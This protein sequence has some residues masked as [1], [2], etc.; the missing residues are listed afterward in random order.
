MHVLLIATYELGHQ[1]YS[2]AVMAARLQQ[3]GHHTVSIDTSL[4]PLEDAQIGAADAIGLA[5][6]MHTATRLAHALLPRLRTLNPT[7]LII[8]FGLYA[9]LN[10]ELLRAAGADYCLAGEVEARFVEL[11]A[12]RTAADA[13]DRSEII[14]A[15]RRIAGQAAAP[16]LQPD[17]RGF[18]PLD[19]YAKLIT[20]RGERIAGYT[21][22][23]RGCKH[24]CRHCPVVPIYNGR[25]RAIDRAAVLAD[26]RAQVAAGAEH[27]TF[28]DPDFLNGPGHALAIVR[29][30][31]AE[32]PQLTYDAT[33]KVEHLLRHQQLL[34]EL[35]ATGC[36]LIVS[37]VEAL[38]DAILTRFD[39][40]HST[41]DVAAA[42]ALLRANDIALSATFVAFTPWTTREVYRDLLRQIAEL[43]LIDAVAPIQYTLRLLIPQ[44][45]RLLELDE[46]RQLVG[47]F[48][49]AGLVYPWQHP[50][51]AIDQLQRSAQWLAQGSG[52]RG[53]TRRRFFERLLDLV[54]DQIGPGPRPSLEHLVPR[55]PI[56]YLNEPW[57]C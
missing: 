18:L 48:D 21:E 36:I 27:I 10:A 34:P 44:G 24:L 54:D 4:Q 29:A 5:V 37:A 15:R 1:P 53:E 38:D 25:F 51:P 55:P 40:R 8:C 41:A 30:L 31:H 9:P 6:P 57:Y 52:P 26:I 32:F 17:R 35:R 3:A 43:D 56:P 50:D 16:L 20:P 45:S 12:D 46:V 39:K 7:A 14:A 42:A 22:T 23:T 28:G 2:L 49:A 13:G 19:R 47:P 11:L 33:I